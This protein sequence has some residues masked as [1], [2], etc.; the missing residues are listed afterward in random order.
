MSALHSTL[1]PEP[2]LPSDLSPDLA[3]EAAHAEPLAQVASRLMRGLPVLVECDKELSPYVFANVRGRLRPAGIQC[4]Y[5]DGRPR[6]TPDPAAGAAGLRVRREHA[7][8][9]S[10]RR[11]GGR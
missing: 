11:P 4:L 1:I 5:L 8:P 2:E 3:V 7:Q 9:A 6:G 10:R